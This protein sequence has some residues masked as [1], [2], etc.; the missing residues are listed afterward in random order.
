[1][2]SLKRHCTPDF[3]LSLG[4]FPLRL[5]FYSSRRF[6]LTSLFLSKYWWIGHWS[7][8]LL[9]K[10]ESETSNKKGLSTSLK[11]SS[12]YYNS[13]LHT[14]KLDF[15]GKVS[16]RGNTD[17]SEGLWNS[18]CAIDRSM[19]FVLVSK[20]MNPVHLYTNVLLLC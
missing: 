13:G 18:K 3:Q 7:M 10:Q 16:L 5:I 11:H 4:G 8:C 2:T 14:M 9:V 20:F 1:M 6:F 15:K 12:N 17:G 19:G